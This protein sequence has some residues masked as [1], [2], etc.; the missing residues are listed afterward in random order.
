MPEVAPLIQV[1]VEG[2]G[3]AVLVGKNDLTDAGTTANVGPIVSVAKGRL[4][5][6]IGC[7]FGL[8][9]DSPRPF[10]RGVIG[11]SL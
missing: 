10:V 3:E 1:G 7:L 5:A 9:A 11:V 2:F 4:W 8:T 6:S